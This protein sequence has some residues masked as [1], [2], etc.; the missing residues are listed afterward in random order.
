MA[1]PLRVPGRLGSSL[2]ECGYVLQVALDYTSLWDAVALASRIGVWRGLA[3][4]VG[5]PLLK[6]YGARD[7]VAALR[8]V[9]GGEAPVVVDT[10][11]ADASDVEADIVASAGGDAF[12]VV[13][14]AHEVTLKQASDAAGTRGLAVY[15]DLVV[16][17]DPLGDAKRAV[18]AGVHI[19]L[20]HLGLD[21]QRAL[22][23]TASS[24]VDLVRR[25]SSEIDAT[26]AVAGGVKPREAG[27]WHQL[28]PL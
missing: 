8:G 5:T 22:G 23:V 7:S 10:K 25:M 6:A 21:V 14:A 27:A 12:T 9:A 17:R 2:A 3:L 24:R 26:I 19:V 18:E 28:V 11:T 1:G 13:A 4:E 16:S 15:G 20:L